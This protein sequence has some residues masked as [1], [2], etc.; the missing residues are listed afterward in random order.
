MSRQDRYIL[1]ELLPPFLFGVGAFLVILVGVSGLYEMLKMIFRQGFPLI[2]ALKIFALRLPGTVTL[3][4]P[5]AM[6]FGSLMA[7]S[8]LSGDGELTALRAGGVGIA[9]IGMPVI[10]VGLVVSASSL[11]INELL[12]PPFNNAAFEIAKRAHETTA[13]EGDMTFEV[14]DS[15]GRLAQ[16]LYGGHFDL[17]TMTVTNAL[18]VDCTRGNRPQIYYAREVKWQGD[19]WVLENGERTWWDDQGRS[20]RAIA[21]HITVSVGG[22]P[23][24]LQRLRK[25]PEDMSLAELATAAQEY[26]DR[27]DTTSAGR[28]LQHAQMR[29]AMPW[30]SLGFAMLGLPLGI[31]K[32]RSSRG[33]GMGMSL[34]VIFAYYAIMHTLSIVG[35]HSTANHAL[36][37][38]GP[39]VLLYL[40][41][42][43]LLLR[44]S[45]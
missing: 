26:M 45:R 17:A 10:I 32:T 8:R 19:R 3:T 36:L 40:A 9:R 23:E 35:E 37:A 30:S 15:Q 11:C 42:I 24:Q 20:R 41:G 25:R 34:A 14:R 39:N 22:T 28:L 43:G 27:G 13:G 6:M 31:R 18:I 1:T 7:M 33:I 2:A 5:M 38:W 44:G 16:W 4:L 12:V 21:D 29:L